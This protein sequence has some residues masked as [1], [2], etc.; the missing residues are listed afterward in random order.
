MGLEELYRDIILDHYRSPRN[1]GTLEDATVRTHVHNALCGDEIELALKVQDD[2][3]AQAR[4]VGRGCSISQASASMMTEA[5]QGLSLD[6]ARELM[7]R[8]VLLV[9][10]EL[11]PQQ[12]ALGELEALSGV[13]HF[14]VRVKCALLP[15]EALDK[16]LGEL[17]ARSSAGGPQ[18]V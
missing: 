16:S 4:F 10:G 5:I 3:I 18:G 17:Q 2:R 13:S 12:A 15:W 1:R 14:P 8:V 9:R 6:D 7:R 11:A